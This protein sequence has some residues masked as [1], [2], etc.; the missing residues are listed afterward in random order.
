[1]NRVI[2]ISAAAALL[3]VA[4]VFVWAG[5]DVAY[6]AENDTVTLTAPA[7][8][9][10]VAELDD[11]ATQVLNDPWDMNN[12]EDVDKPNN[13]VNYGVNGGVWTGTATTP[14]SSNVYFQYQ[15]IVNAQHTDGSFSYLGEKR[16]LTTLW[17]AAASPAC[18]YA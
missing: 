6:G 5:R 18:G 10:V 8:N 16:A 1:M 11:Y 3:I 2:R 12:S 9:T 17:T 15:D 13:V 14:A 4:A 7:P